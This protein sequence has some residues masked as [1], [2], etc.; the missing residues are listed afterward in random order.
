MF[1]FYE[2]VIPFL[3]IINSYNP[4]VLGDAIVEC[5]KKNKPIKEE[6]ERVRNYFSC[7]RMA[8]DTLDIYKRPVKK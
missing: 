6:V 4:D 7:E 2:N 5:M 1:L 8:K 3:E